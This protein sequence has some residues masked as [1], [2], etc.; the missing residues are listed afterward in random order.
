MTEEAPVTYEKHDVAEKNVEKLNVAENADKKLDTELTITR[1]SLRERNGKIIVSPKKLLPK[2]SAEQI[3]E[4]LNLKMSLLEG[5]HH[6]ICA[7]DLCGNFVVSG[8]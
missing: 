1:R 6:D 4:N 2:S 3:F 7:I 8:G 5:H